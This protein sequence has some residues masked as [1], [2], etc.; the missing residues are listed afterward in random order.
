MTNKSS[1]F[2]KIVNP[3]QS[4]GQNWVSN[5]T[6]ILFMT[7]NP[8]DDIAVCFTCGSSGLNS[9]ECLKK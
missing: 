1:S 5:S 8:S 2:H 6:N 9:V 7:P 4:S 3:N